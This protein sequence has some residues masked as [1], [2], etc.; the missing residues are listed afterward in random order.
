MLLWKI[1][2]LGRKQVQKER[3]MQVTKKKRDQNR[4]REL[5]MKTN[6]HCLM[7]EATEG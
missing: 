3:L 2:H 6:Q 7:S 1:I 4:R 5:N